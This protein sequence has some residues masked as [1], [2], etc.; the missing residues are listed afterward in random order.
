MNILQAIADPKLFGPWFSEGE[1]WRAWRACLAA[2]FALDMSEDELAIYQRCT[3]REQPPSTQPR[4]VWLLCGRRSGKSFITALIATYIAA[5]TKHKLKRGETG[6]VLVMA[7]DRKQAGVVLGYARGLF[8]NVPMLRKLV[9]NETTTAIELTNGVRIEVN[10]AS[11]SAVRG[12]LCVAVVAD[13][14]AFWRSENTLSPDVEILRAV[15]P[16]LA[17]QPQALLLCI[18]SP[19]LRRGAMWNAYR[20]HFGRDG[21][22]VLFWKADTRTMNPCVP[23]EEIEAAYREDAASAAAEFGAE[24]RSDVESF[25]SFEAIDPLVD[26]DVLERGRLDGLAYHAFCDPSG[27]SSDSMTLAIAHCEDGVGVLDVLRER[28]PPF[29]PDAVAGEFSDLLKSF[30]L[31]TVTG[32]RYGGSWPAERF[33]AHGVTYIASDRAKSEIY[34]DA[35]PLLNSRR[36]ALLDNEALVRQLIALER[37][38]GRAGRD[39]IDHGPG[40]HDDLVNSALGALLLA[41]RPTLPPPRLGIIDIDLGPPLEPVATLSR[42]LQ[43]ISSPGDAFPGSDFGEWLRRGWQ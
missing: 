37:R 35:L 2:I 31:L 16:A 12:Y 4:E 8:H 27:G 36:V 39:S 5:F 7:A 10:T 13:E 25:I 33:R 19:Y 43:G 17:T 28:K 42:P 24:F 30:G 34:R 15:R 22:R 20:E 29:D 18:S 9:A 40:G 1:T 6:T 3:G 32:D 11:V 23:T 41:A 26:R 21:D 14:I 38:T